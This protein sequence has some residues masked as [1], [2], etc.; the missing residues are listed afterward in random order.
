MRSCPNSSRLA[1]SNFAKIINLRAF[2]RLNMMALALVVIAS[3]SA[4]LAQSVYEPNL[5]ETNLEQSVNGDEWVVFHAIPMK[6]P[7]R[8]FAFETYAIRRSQMATGG[9]Y[10]CV[11][12]HRCTDDVWV[13]GDHRFNNSVRYRTSLTRYAIR[14][15]GWGYGKD[16]VVTYNAEG[17][18]IDQ[19]DRTDK[20][21][22][23]VPGSLEELVARKFC[24]FPR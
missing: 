19:W 22:A 23:I 9:Q 10:L 8:V 24:K 15:R 3:A 12:T 21:R 4:G 17:R 13:K 11:G 1:A 14:C 6:H 2:V 16:Q 20:L 18:I 5:A 7:K